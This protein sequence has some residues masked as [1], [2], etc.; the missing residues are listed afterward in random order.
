M[1][2]RGV[3]IQVDKAVSCA[4]IIYFQSACLSLSYESQRIHRASKKFDAPVTVDWVGMPFSV[5]ME[6]LA[7]F[8]GPISVFF[9]VDLSA[10][11]PKKVNPV[12]YEQESFNK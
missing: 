7:M 4:C 9:F 5:D 12:C 3:T 11:A 2:A 1:I 6:L 8:S 10:L